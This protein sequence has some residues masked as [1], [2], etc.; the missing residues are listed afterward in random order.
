[1]SSLSHIWVTNV[2]SL[3]IGRLLTL[4]IVSFTVQRSL[5]SSHVFVT[6][7]AACTFGIVATK[8]LSKPKSWNFSPVFCDRN[9]VVLGLVLRSLAHFELIFVYGVKIRVQVHS[10]VRGCSVF[11]APLGEE[12]VLPSLN[13][14]GYLWGVIWPQTGGFIFGLYPVPSIYVTVLKPVSHCFCKSVICFKTK[15]CEKK[16]RSVSAPTLF[17]K[18]V[19]AIQGP[20]WFHVNFRMAS[21]FLQKKK[22]TQKTKQNK[23]KPCYWHFDKDFI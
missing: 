21:L 7:F 17:L 4:P 18:I 16:T 6:A 23:T 8:S 22:K 1:M 11:P 14:L 5:V 10:P 3:S 12:T 19:L 20:L 13:S 9:F 15:K 2:F